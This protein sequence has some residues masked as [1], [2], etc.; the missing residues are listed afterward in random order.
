MSVT[1]R[2]GYAIEDNL[3]SYNFVGCDFGPATATRRIIVVASPQ[4]GA[5]VTANV[6]AMTI[7]GVTAT[8]VIGFTSGRFHVAIWMAAV[9]T[10]TSGDIVVTTPTMERCAIAVY[11]AD[12][13]ASDT[14][15]SSASDGSTPQSVSLTTA[16][17][18]FVIAG[19]NNA[20]GGGGYVWT[21]VVE[22]YFYTP[23]ESH[24]NSPGFS[25]AS[26]KTF[27]AG[28]LTVT[29]DPNN[30]DA[31]TRALVAA[32]W[33]TTDAPGD[34]LTA[35]QGSY[36]ISGQA[37]AVAPQ[38]NL[39]AVQG[40][41]SIVGKDAI[42]AAKLVL[43]AGFGRYSIGI[44]NRILDSSDFNSANW[45]QVA[46]TVVSDAAKAPDGTM[47]AD[48][49]IDTNTGVSQQHYFQQFVPANLLLP[50]T[51]FAFV[52][53][54]PG[55]AKTQ[56]YLSSYAWPSVSEAVSSRFDLSTGAIVG[57]PVLVGS[58]TVIDAGI[59]A[60]PDN[61]YRV[62][63]TIN[64]NNT[65]TQLLARLIYLNNANNS[66]SYVGD[67][68][69]GF[70]VWDMH[71][72]QDSA[73]LQF[74]HKLTAAQGS[75]AFAGQSAGMFDYRVITATQGS[76]SIVG[77]DA[78]LAQAHRLIAQFANYVWSGKD[79]SII[80]GKFVSGSQGSYLI[81]G[82]SAIIAYAHKLI[83]DFGIYSIAGQASILAQAHKL[84]ASQGGYVWSGK[85]AI[86]QYGRHLNANTGSYLITGEDVLLR[87]AHR[88]KTVAVI[89]I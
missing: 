60:L 63:H 83:S 43:P 3:T 9:P 49:V 36:S 75:Y 8:K 21:G 51:Q 10:G 76:Y 57:S 40:S 48:A 2:A 24:T 4:R 26:V 12:N 47:T 67:D 80:G 25:A 15:V 20:F 42:L 32:A 86:P 17:P 41:Y 13:L 85:A 5:D 7:G 66:S 50:L 89:M 77:K 78:I 14:P 55:A 81:A 19:D 23:V 35:D 38:R 34:V 62:W 61:W 69:S 74:G 58:P 45:S 68:V 56:L 53:L 70:Y 52:K 65:D 87:Q 22:D 16:N 59:D 37:A 64:L 84:I 6:T 71:V 72:E 11:A 29:A 79:A 46:T 30:A 1:F 31:S 82:Q 27:A 44:P 73:R 88:R 54:L 18:G 33:E 39:P 28:S